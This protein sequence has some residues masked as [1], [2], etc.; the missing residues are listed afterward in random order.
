MRIANGKSP[1]NATT[2]CTA[3]GSA[4]TRSSAAIR[5]NNAIASA[6]GSTSNDRMRAASRSASRRRLV[7]NVKHLAVPGNSGRTCAAVAALSNTTTAL[8]SANSARHRAARASMSCG[9]CPPGTPSARN[10]TSRAAVG[11]VGARPGVW[12][13]RSMNICASG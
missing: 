8:R 12:P 7:I 2:C 6:R 10:S 13:C 3:A 9:I 1:H 5:A 11:S 4:A